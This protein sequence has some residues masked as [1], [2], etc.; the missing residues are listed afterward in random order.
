MDQSGERSP[1]RASYKAN[2]EMKPQAP[3]E[4]GCWPSV[5][6][7]LESSTAQEQK[8]KD[9][10]SAP[11]CLTS[12]TPLPPSQCLCFLSVKWVWQPDRRLKAGR[13]LQHPITLLGSGGHGCRG[14]PGTGVGPVQEELEKHQKGKGWPGWSPE[15][16]NESRGR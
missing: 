7:V 15:R 9:Q 4:R 13:F 10:V 3:S 14:F 2:C 8:L 6:S 1:R 11:C 16:G 12:R 5:I